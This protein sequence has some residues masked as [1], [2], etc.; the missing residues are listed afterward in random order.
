MK[1]VRLTSILLLAIAATPA[2]AADDLRISGFANFTAGKVLSGSNQGSL[3]GLNV[4]QCPCYM[5]NYEYGGIY[6]DAGW[7]AA[8]ES[9]FGVQADFRVDEK[10]SSTVQAVARGVNNYTASVDWAYLTYALGDKW[11]VQAGHKRLPLYAYSDSNYIGYSYTWVRPPVDLYGWEIY[12]YNG[13]NA[14]YKG[15]F[16]DLDF[17]GNIWAG[18]QSEPNNV[19]YS[20]VYYDVPTKAEWRDILGAYTEFGNEI[21][22]LRLTYMQNDVT[23]SQLQGRTVT[24]LYEGP[25]KVYGAALNADFLGFMWRS[26]YNTFKR[27]PT[28]APSW[29]AGIGYRIGQFSAMYTLSEYR[30]NSLF[31]KN[32]TRATTLRWDFHKKIALK[33]Q[34]EDYKDQSQVPYLGDS[35]VA[36]ISLAMVF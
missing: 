27:P 9:V 16:G 35:E 7:S 19:L 22:R 2:F 3:G 18:S 28:E 13:I 4:Y 25:Q 21:L 14:M 30:D 6:Q 29:L 5:A 24:S 23:L 20:G 11:V 34:Y 8:P 17:T 15:T 10:L 1:H 36:T 26:E 31:L 33:A 32:S 12:A